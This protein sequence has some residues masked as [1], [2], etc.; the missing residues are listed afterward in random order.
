MQFRLGLVAVTLVVGT[1]IWASHGDTTLTTTLRTM[2]M[3]LPDGPV[4]DSIS[5]EDIRFTLT[6]LATAQASI[7]AIVFSITFI[8]VQL[9]SSNY[10]LRT[11]G[12]LAPRDL[13]G[14]GYYALGVSLI[15]DVL[16]LVGLPAEA[17]AGYILFT[18]FAVMLFVGSLYL[19][20]RTVNQTMALTT[21]KGLTER[22]RANADIKKTLRRET[23]DV[24]PTDALYSLTNSAIKNGEWATVEE[25]YDE[26][27]SLVDALVT[28]VETQGQQHSTAAGGDVPDLHDEIDTA[29]RDALFG[30]IFGSQYQ[31]IIV[32]AAERGNEEKVREYI[33]DL[34]TFG[35][36][37]FNG[38]IPTLGMDVFEALE[39][40]ST[41]LE[42][43]EIDSEFPLRERAS[44][45]EPAVKHQHIPAAIRMQ[46]SLRNATMA[47]EGGR[48]TPVDVAPATHRAVLITTC[49]S[50]VSIMNH[51]DLGIPPQM[52]LSQVN[53]DPNLR[54]HQDLLL[55]LTN[56]FQAYMLDWGVWEKHNDSGQVELLYDSVEYLSRAGGL[57][58]LDAFLTPLI[59]QLVSA[60]L[61]RE[62]E[63]QAQQ[64]QID[65]MC[66]LSSDDGGLAA[67]TGSIH[68]GSQATHFLRESLCR[69]ALG[70]T[71]ATVKQAIAG[72]RSAIEREIARSGLGDQPGWEGRWLESLRDVDY[73]LCLNRLDNLLAGFNPAYRILLFRRVGKKQVYNG[74]RESPEAFL[75]SEPSATTRLDE[76]VFLCELGRGNPIMVILCDHTELNTEQGHQESVTL[77]ARLA[78]TALVRHHSPSF[79]LLTCHKDRESGPFD[80][81][82]E[83]NL[84]GCLPDAQSALSEFVYP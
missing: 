60:W 36:R 78:E 46:K 25:G 74:F 7:L 73:E 66:P 56:Q 62:P 37:G 35:E 51:G 83:L 39:T 29:R 65:G 45:L 1:G 23:D 21:P 69:I 67:E 17:N 79:R 68:D 3:A 5:S 34:R 75:D 13:F 54:T 59:R 40:I 71:Q 22:L 11:L 20:Q 70:N 27:H 33:E 47:T 58:R 32:S 9:V 50:I 82:I 18:G 57:T 55:A 14:F 4:T 15:V 81:T 12:Q 49:R 80:E 38:E 19:L 42:G 41:A 61:Q 72:C 8:G 2:V 44:L 52:Q 16:L 76:R 26:Y 63:G 43:S 53:Q 77:Q 6:T 10:T 48:I 84:A 31:H 24:G 30:E 64:K 28:E